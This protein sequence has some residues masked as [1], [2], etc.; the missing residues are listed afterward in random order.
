M[1]CLLLLFFQLFFSLRDLK[2]DVS[3]TE[4]KVSAFLCSTIVHIVSKSNLAFYGKRIEKKKVI[5]KIICIHFPP[6]GMLIPNLR[7]PIA[8]K[9]IYPANSHVEQQ[10]DFLPK[11]IECIQSNHH[12]AEG[13]QINLAWLLCLLFI[14]PTTPY[15]LP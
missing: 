15:L 12:L 14:S 9:I 7:A 8:I 10:I 1:S 4:G 3:R 6:S 5:L 2:A 13:V 11:W